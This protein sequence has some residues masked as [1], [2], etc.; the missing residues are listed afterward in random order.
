M[1]FKGY[2]I[3]GKMNGEGEYTIANSYTFVGN[4]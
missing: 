2:Y 3:N 4:F 1:T